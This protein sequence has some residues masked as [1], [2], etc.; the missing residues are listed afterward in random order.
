MHEFFVKKD[1]SGPASGVV[2]GVN[3][4][5]N[6]DSGRVYPPEEIKAMLKK[7]GFKAPR[8]HRLRDT[9]VV[10]AGR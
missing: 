2:F 9:V 8:A 7:A 4:L 1:R 10:I 6:T 5:V 3:M